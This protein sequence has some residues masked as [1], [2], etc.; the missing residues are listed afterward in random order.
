MDRNTITIRGHH[1]SAVM[2]E[3]YNPGLMSDESVVKE[4]GARN[5]K[6]TQKLINLVLQSDVN[7]T[8]VDGLDDMCIDCFGL[9]KGKDCTG[10][11]M[12][13]YDR[14]VASKY[15]LEIG[16]TYTSTE[17]RKRIKERFGEEECY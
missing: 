15:G 12:S 16:K 10:T 13:E 11:D 9:N 3:M 8:I 4:H 1:L 2:E 7:V 14:D 5:I 17:I 6:E